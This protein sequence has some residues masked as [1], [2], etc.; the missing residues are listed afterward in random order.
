MNLS[1]SLPSLR[2][3]AGCRC[4]PQQTG[5]HGLEVN[6]TIEAV[7][8]LSEITVGIFCKIERMIGPTQ[9]GFQVASRVLTQLKLGTSVL[10]R[11]APTT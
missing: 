10:R 11:V 2:A 1:H 7:L 8:V 9:S 6:A 5:Q 3:T 4:S